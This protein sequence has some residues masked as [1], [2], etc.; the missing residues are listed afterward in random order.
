MHFM[1]IRVNTI[2]KQEGMNRFMNRGY[3]IKNMIILSA[4]SVVYAAG[5]GLFL[6]PSSLAPGGVVGISV[7]LNHFLHIG[8]GT[9]NFLIN[10][11]ILILG[12]VKFGKKFMAKTAYVVILS[13]LLTNL[14]SMSG[15]VTDEILLAAIAGSILTGTGIGMTFRAGATSGGMD[16]IVKAL[17]TKYRHMKT[18]ALFL[19]LDIIVVAVSGVVFSDF[20]LAMYAFIA[21]FTASRVMDY[22]LYGQDEARLIYIVS[23]NHEK[24]AGRLLADLDVGATYLKGIGAYSNNDKHVIMCVV[25]KMQSPKVE[26]IVKSEDKNAFMIISSASEIYGEG[27]KNLFEEVV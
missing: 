26:E 6:A 10:I 18:S 20:N 19:I 24:I 3:F 22:V 1:K 25:R 13:S 21:V 15:P 12:F 2:N 7:I 9:F 5:I 11:P 23:N 8:T 16:I 27:Y 17:R 4:A 14:F